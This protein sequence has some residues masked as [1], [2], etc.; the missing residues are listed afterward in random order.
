MI[1]LLRLWK[2]HF[3]LVEWLIALLLTGGF[4]IWFERYG[5]A[6]SI[7]TVLKG[8]RATLYGT[9]ASIFGSLLGFAITATS[10]VLGF[11]SSDRLAVLR[12]SAHYPTL[13][14]TFSATIRALAL[15]TV[16]ALV[17][18]VW[19][20]DNQPASWLTVVLF[21]SVLL[22]IFRIGRTIWVLEQIIALVTIPPLNHKGDS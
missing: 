3:L 9:A 11:S 12:G 16:I 10:I 5:G 1:W 14:K 7:E 15:A 21:F 20:R 22:A 6:A 19:D 17:C 4:Y 8:N 13:W 2:Q 18:L